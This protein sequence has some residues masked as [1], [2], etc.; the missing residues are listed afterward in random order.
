[1][2]IGLSNAMLVVGVLACVGA[3]ARAAAPRDA[4]CRGNPGLTGQCYW[5]RG[6]VELSFD[7]GYV[8]GRDDSYRVVIITNAP[9][10][11]KDVPSNLMHVMDQAVKNVSSA[12]AWVHGTFEVCPIPTR[13]PD[14]TYEHFVCIQ[15]AVHLRPQRLG[16]PNPGTQSRHR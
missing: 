1:M 12:S 4:G 3:P 10:S 2:N 8:L 7:R 9:N 6:T 5:L 14:L 16:D 11:E 15:S 13:R